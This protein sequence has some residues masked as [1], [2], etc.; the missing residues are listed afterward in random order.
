M[1][2][3]DGCELDGT[4]LDGLLENGQNPEGKPV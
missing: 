3:H 1:C 4:G 2:V